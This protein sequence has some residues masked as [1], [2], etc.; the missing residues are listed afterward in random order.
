MIDKVSCEQ[1]VSRTRDNKVS[2]EQADRCG[3]GDYHRYLKQRKVRIER[4]RAKANP[5]CAPAY[6]LYRGYET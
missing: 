4:R 5:T 6:R 3:G 2:C 1:D